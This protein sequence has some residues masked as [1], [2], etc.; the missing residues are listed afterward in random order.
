[1]HFFFRQHQEAYPLTRNATFPLKAKCPYRPTKNSEGC[2][3]ANGGVYLPL[4]QHM[5]MF[6]LSSRYIQCHQYVKG[7]EHIMAREESRKKGAGQINER[8]KFPRISQQLYLKMYVSDTDLDSSKIHDFKAR[9][10][11]IS[12]GGLRIE[13]P[14]ELTPG[15]IVCFETDEEITSRKISG[16]GE[17]RWCK[18]SVKSDS[19]EFGIAFPDS[20]QF[21]AWG[22]IYPTAYWLP[23]TD[24]PGPEIH[25]RN[26]VTFFSGLASPFAPSTCSIR[27]IPPAD[28]HF[29]IPPEWLKRQRAVSNEKWTGTELG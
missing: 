27:F 15:S 13:S 26:S 16:I 4:P 10:L 29:S 8:R 22:I 24:L 12:L 1:M 14:R 28:L 17:V 7:C 21:R 18:P 6:C 3:I 2:G 5:N 9:T 23:C 11:D 25:K 19:Y 20:I